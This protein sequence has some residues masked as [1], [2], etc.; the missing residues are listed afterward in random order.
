[1]TR[2]RLLFCL[3]CWLWLPLSPEAQT[4]KYDLAFKTWGEFYMPWQDWQWWKAQGRAESGLNPG[5]ASY[6]GAVG[7][8]QLMPATAKAMGVDPTDPEANIRG[9]IHYDRMLWDGWPAIAASDRIAFTFAGYNAGPGN[10]R[11]ARQL[12]SN[13]TWPAVAQALPHVTGK[14][15][16]ETVN[17]VARIRA[18]YLGR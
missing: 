8:M 17:Y 4:L 6:C 7:V 2:K 12:A 5:A 16:T 15:S 1:M 10:I 3:A 9:G 14:H 13:G 11:K 18:F